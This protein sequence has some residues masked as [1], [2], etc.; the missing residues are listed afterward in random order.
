MANSIVRFA[1]FMAMYPTIDVCQ[2]TWLRVLRTYANSLAAGFYGRMPTRWLR[3]STDVCQRNLATDFAQLG[4]M[5]EDILDF[6]R[7]M[8]GW[9]CEPIHNGAFQSENMKLSIGMYKYVI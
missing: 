2:F 9:L 4:Y 5:Y 1:I 7:V 6:Y 3:V 8:L